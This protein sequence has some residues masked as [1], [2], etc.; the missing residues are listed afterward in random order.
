MREY[1]PSEL[2]CAPAPLTREQALELPI[3]AADR[4][5][6]VWLRFG[7]QDLVY[8]FDDLGRTEEVEWVPAADSGV[9]HF[10][11]YYGFNS[12]WSPVWRD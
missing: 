1:D 10:E 4:G 9:Y 11:Y 7:E 8:S 2:P 6:W 5:R 3:L 12:L